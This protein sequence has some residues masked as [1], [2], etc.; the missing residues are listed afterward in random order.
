MLGIPNILDRVIQQA[1][2]QLLTPFYDPDFSDY[3]HGFRLGR[4]A[5]DAVYHIKAGLRQ[6]Y[7][8]AVDVDLAKFFDRV[9]HDVLMNRLSRRISD[10]RVLRLIGLYL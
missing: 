2:S 3:S 10:K 4:R 5:G 7:T 9:N 6:G 8:S 1:I